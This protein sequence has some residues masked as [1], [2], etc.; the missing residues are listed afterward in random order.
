MQRN[1]IPDW[2]LERFRLGELP[3][4]ELQAIRQAVADDQ[5][6]RARMAALDRSDQD[7]RNAYPSDV[8]AQ[9]IRQRT[10]GLE[11]SKGIGRRVWLSALALAAV[12]A[13]GV[14]TSLWEPDPETQL[15]QTR[16]KGAHP[17]LLLFRKTDAGT[18][19]LANGARARAGDLIQIFYQAAGRSYGAIVSVDGRGTTTLHLPESG[20]QPAV[21]KQGEPVALGF[22]YELDDA[23]KWERFYL[24]TSNTPFDAQTVFAA[25]KGGDGHAD[26]LRLSEA[27]EQVRFTLYKDDMP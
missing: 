9:R 8:M 18:E 1:D 22:A 7:I 5:D 16:L 20:R 11:L 25:A 27:F 3:D 12:V 4:A 13:L 15:E 14:T 10:L 23:P 6:L 26:S 17:R 21:L 24:V 2:K 19:V